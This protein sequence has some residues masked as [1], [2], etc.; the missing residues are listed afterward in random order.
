MVA[1]SAPSDSSTETSIFSSID[2]RSI[3]PD[4]S[5][6]EFAKV[7]VLK[8]V[9]VR[10]NSVRIERSNLHM[11]KKVNGF[12][13]NLGRFENRQSRKNYEINAFSYRDVTNF[14]N[15]RVKKMKAYQIQ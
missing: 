2:C 9:R 3:A 14:V 8:K 6:T 10:A 12:V 15:A 5:P 1:V 13:V 7:T 11:L 4:Q